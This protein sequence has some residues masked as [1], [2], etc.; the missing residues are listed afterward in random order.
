MNSALFLVMSWVIYKHKDHQGSFG[1]DNLCW[2]WN[3]VLDLLDPGVKSNIDWSSI[4]DKVVG[5]FD[6]D[7]FNSFNGFSN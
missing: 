5:T 3:E 7:L 6:N 2:L 4:S 1:K